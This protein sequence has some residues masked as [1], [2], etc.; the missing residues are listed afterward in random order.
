[1]GTIKERS[2][3]DIIEAED[4]KKKWQEYKEKL[5][6]KGLNDPDNHNDVITYLEPNIPESEVKWSL[7][8]TTMRKASG[9]DGT[10][11]ELFE[12]LAKS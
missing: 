12:D 9:D 3:K 1:M 7:G 6:K 10:P 5:Y 11:S 4:I 8:S 2:G